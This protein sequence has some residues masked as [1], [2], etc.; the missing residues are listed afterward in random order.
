MAA[1]MRAGRVTSE[2]LVAQSL[3]RIAK[4]DGALHSCLA[5]APREDALRA[6]REQDRLRAGGAAP[7]PL[8]GVPILVKDNICTRAFP[9]TCGSK[10]LEGY[11]PAYD[12]TVVERLAAAGLIIVGKT[13]LDEFAMGSSTENSG[14]GPTK[15]PWD[16]ARVPGGSS[17]GS[18]A[19]V[20]AGLVPLALGSDT[21][22]SVRQ[23]ASF[24]GVVG[25]KPSY[26]R[27]SRYGLVAFA[28]SLDQIGP[29]ARSVEDVAL[30]LEIVAGRDARDATSG[31]RPVGRYA[32]AL[33]GDT[34]AN[35]LRGIRI[36]IPKEYFVPGLD[37]E[38]ARAVERALDIA[39]E[40]GA[41]VSEI[42]LPH[43]V[44]GVATYYLVATAEAS[45]NLARFDGVRYGHR[46]RG[47]RGLREMYRATRREG[48]GSEVKRRI[49]LGTFALSSGYY[50]AY[51]A[52]AQ[53]VRGLMRR[54]F[55]QAFDSVDLILGPTA[56]TP[57][58]R[59]GEKDDPLA[60]YLSDIYT[61]P[62]NLAE[63]PGISIPAALSSD[64]V[65][66]GIQILAN[67]FDEERL[68][69][70]TNALATRL[71]FTVTPPAFPE[72]AS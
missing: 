25:L 57:A 72:S 21:G 7:S 23:P 13:N 34:G 56:P 46:A 8:A 26:G 52:K 43:I 44:H 33:A 1:D 47:E 29:F 42:S 18:A 36:G 20:A 17:G 45:S 28:S 50:D 2:A 39:R 53:A 38:V 69:A 15:N 31:D 32:D 22:G 71:A 49:I 6:A 58:F 27:V 54:D 24:C 37:D 40:A 12:A 5:V 66:I 4:H 35:A 51:Y 68:L 30:L 3:D 9:T 62:A 10:I 16:L 63:L 48:F 60:M 11:R 14:Y 41:T 64:G 19:A 67:A 70:A 61:L 55:A 59:F 65:P